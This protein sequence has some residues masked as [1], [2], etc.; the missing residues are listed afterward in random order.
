MSA[1]LS[2]PFPAAFALPRRRM[3]LARAIALHGALLMALLNG[4]QPE[5]IDIRESAGYQRLD[6]AARQAVLR[7][8]FK[9]HLEDGRPVPAYVMVPISFAL[10]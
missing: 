4:M 10:R 6:E 5:R 8:S 3:P 2:S 9:P 1:V 7:A